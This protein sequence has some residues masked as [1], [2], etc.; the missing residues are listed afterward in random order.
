MKFKFYILKIS[1][2]TC[3]FI[4]PSVVISKTFFNIYTSLYIYQWRRKVPKSVCVGGGEGGTQTRNL[5]S[6]WI[7]G[8]LL[9]A[10]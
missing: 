5:C 3:N 9:T 7:Y 1:R 8:Y 6:F 2:P 4:S 10:I